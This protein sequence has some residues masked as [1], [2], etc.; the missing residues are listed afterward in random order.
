MT[1]QIKHEFN[2]AAQAL[3]DIVGTPD[4]IDWVPGVTE[5]VFD[6]EIRRL[7][8]PGAGQ[9]AEKILLRDDEK[10]RLEYSCI[11]SIPPLDH[12]LATI[13]LDSIDED[14]CLMHWKTEVIPLAIEPFIEKSMQGC[15]K[16]LEELLM[17]Q[18]GS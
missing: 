17:P 2:A 9:I 5:C 16:Q 14:R 13:Q 1:I 4:R 3:W 12:H 15:L 10:M 6:G 7:G 18:P 8:M 11:D